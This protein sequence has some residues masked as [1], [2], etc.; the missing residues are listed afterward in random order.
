MNG[1]V[2]LLIVLFIAG[3]SFSIGALAF[4]YF[5]NKK[6]CCFGL[7]NFKKCFGDNVGSAKN[8]SNSCCKDKDTWLTINDLKDEDPN[9][10]GYNKYCK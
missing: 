2:V 6:K 8:F 3:L 5:F 9:T 4:G 1:I 7:D 10:N